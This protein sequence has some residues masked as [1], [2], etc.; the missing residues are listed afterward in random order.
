MKY[1]VV[2]YVTRSNKYTREIRFSSYDKALALF[3][4]LERKFKYLSEVNNGV[5]NC[6]QFHKQDER[7]E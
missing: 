1:Y 6:L 2:W 3:N 7:S 5:Y 4:A